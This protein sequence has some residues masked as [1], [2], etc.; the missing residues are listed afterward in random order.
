[1][2]DIIIRNGK[3]VDGTGSPAFMGEIGI[4][5]DRIVEV[6]RITESA[7]REIDATDRI[8]TPGFVDTHTHLDAQLFWDPY[9]SPVCWHGSTTARATTLVYSTPRFRPQDQH[10]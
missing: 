4:R 1:M 9:A 2:L 7:V 6:G 10:A 5:G 3:I 8:V